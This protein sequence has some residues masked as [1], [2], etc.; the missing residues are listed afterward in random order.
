MSEIKIERSVFQLVKKEFITPH[1]IRITL[2]GDAQLYADCTIGVNNKILIP[3]KGLKKVH[4]PAFDSEKFEWI[5]PEETIRPIIRTYTHRGID[6]EKNQMI[7]DFVHHGDNGPASSWAL[8]AKEGDEL[9]LAM[10]IGSA[11][12]YPEAHWYFLIGDATALPV[13]SAIMESLPAHAKG[14]ALLE[15]ASRED[16]QALK[17]PEG[18]SIQWLHNSHPEQGSFLADEAQK[19]EIPEGSKFA[20]VAAEFSSVKKLRSYFRKEL[21]WTKDELYA[22]SYWKSGVAEDQSSSERQGEK[23]AE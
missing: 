9:G 10:K 19:I 1:Y 7:V 21:L 6:L 2:E 4:L 18:F 22:Y 5:Y 11:P 17:A 16:E 3:P 14:I 23:N 20:Y 13:L 15:V 12:L 8:H